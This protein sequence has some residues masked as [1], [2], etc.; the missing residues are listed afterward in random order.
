MPPVR[1]DLIRKTVLLTH[2]R[3][4]HSSV[5][6]LGFDGELL[7][8]LM[9]GFL[10]RALTVAIGRRAY[11]FFLQTEDP[12]HPDNRVVE[13]EV[14]GAPPVLDYDPAR[15]P[16][17][18]AEHRRFVRG[19]QRALLSAGLVSFTRRIGLAGTAHACGSLSAGT[20]PATSVVDAAGRV[21]GFEGLYVVDGS[22]LTRSSRVNPSL[23]I[24]AWSLRVAQ[25]LAERLGAART[26][27]AP[28]GILAGAAAPVPSTVA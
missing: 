9:P 14:E 28:A 12:S 24:F 3:Y 15:T 8:T 11:G 1:T 18:D 27:T 23:T 5:Q 13:P 10:P 20:D 25:L 26:G 16:W 4:P 2:A 17:A 21:H 19:F 6:P 22:V 7:G